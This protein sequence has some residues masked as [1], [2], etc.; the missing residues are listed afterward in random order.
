[1]IIK[2]LLFHQIVIVIKQ[3][4]LRLDPLGDYPVLRIIGIPLCEDT[5]LVQSTE[6]LDE[7]L[8]DFY[9]TGKKDLKFLK[10]FIKN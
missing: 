1:M 3:V 5:F 6:D 8:T 9:M 4:D 7:I 2:E 10:K